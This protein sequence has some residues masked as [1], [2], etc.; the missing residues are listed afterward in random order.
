MRQLVSVKCEEKKYTAVNVLGRCDVKASIG[1]YTSISVDILFN[2]KTAKLH[3]VTVCY[4]FI[5]LQ[6]E[7]TSYT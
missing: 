3:L 5:Q 1:E 4:N 7:I 2:D 6:F